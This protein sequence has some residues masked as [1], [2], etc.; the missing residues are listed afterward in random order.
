[1]VSVREMGKEGNGGRRTL[2]TAAR[3]ALIIV[4]SIQ[5]PCGLAAAARMARLARHS[6]LIG[7]LPAGRGMDETMTKACPTPLVRVRQ[8]G[9]YHAVVQGRGGTQR[10][11][12]V[13]AI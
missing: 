1:M 8:P 13:V 9:E 3:Q 12:V 10:R 2:S 7:R 4:W 5:A 6:A 11:Y